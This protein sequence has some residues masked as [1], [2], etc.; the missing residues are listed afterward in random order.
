MPPHAVHPGEILASELKTLGITPKELAR[1]L[2]V[3]VIRINLIVQGKRGISGD[4]AQR[5]GEWFGQNPQFWLSLQSAYDRWQEREAAAAKAA[6]EV[7]VAPPKAPPRLPRKAEPRKRVSKFSPEEMAAFDALEEAP[8]LPGASQEDALCGVLYWPV[9]RIVSLRLD[10]EI[11]EWFRTRH[12]RGYQRMIN[13]VLR[14]YVKNQ[15]QAE[16]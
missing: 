3:P 4:T 15:R 5:L 14:D 16:S 13:A 12:A 6:E 8:D 10:D 7:P 9:K 11:V 1:Q 2:N